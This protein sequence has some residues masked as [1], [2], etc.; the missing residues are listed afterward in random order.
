MFIV[1][2]WVH[3][4]DF[5]VIKWSV[6]GTS[7]TTP[8]SYVAGEALC[9]V[10]GMMV[11]DRSLPGRYRVLLDLAM[12]HSL[13][14]EQIR[15][16]AGMI[17]MVACCCVSCFAE[18]RWKWSQG[19]RLGDGKLAKYTGAAEAAIVVAHDVGPC[20]LGTPA[21]RSIISCFPHHSFLHE[22]KRRCAWLEVKLT[23]AFFPLFT[24][25]ASC[26]RGARSDLALGSSMLILYPRTNGSHGDNPILLMRPVKPTVVGIHS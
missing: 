8:T 2:C 3:G 19:C 7:W 17:A 18:F 25:S 23:S 14:V 24:S 9:F 16:P 13:L 11:A 12:T 5:R 1:L 6:L 22:K 4:L 21:E 20:R 15:L 26:C 10:R